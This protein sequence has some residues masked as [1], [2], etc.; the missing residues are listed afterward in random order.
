[1]S[2]LNVGH[3]SFAPE[4]MQDLIIDFGHLFEVL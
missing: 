3:G 2:R 1:M 4:H